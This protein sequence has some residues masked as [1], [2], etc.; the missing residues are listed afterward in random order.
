MLVQWPGWG[1]AGHTLRQLKE[2]PCVGGEG[3]AIPRE[4]CAVLAGPWH[5]GGSCG[6]GQCSAWLLTLCARGRVVGHWGHVDPH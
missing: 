1:S 5:L 4:L 2:R 3:Q 6:I